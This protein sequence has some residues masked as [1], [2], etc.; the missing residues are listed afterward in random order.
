MG[1]GHD[2]FI[3]PGD[4]DQEGIAVEMQ[5]GGVGDQAHIVA[6]IQ[7]SS[8]IAQIEGGSEQQQMWVVLSEQRADGIYSREGQIIVVDAIG[9]DIDLCRASF[10]EGR[11]KLRG[12]RTA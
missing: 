10:S 11:R 2:I 8:D 7:A 12:G 9:G 1:S 6:R 4:S 3:T 5:I